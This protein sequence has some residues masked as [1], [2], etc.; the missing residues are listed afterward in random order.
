MKIK[1]HEIPV[2]E[3]TEE[4]IAK[5]LQCLYK[6]T[7]NTRLLRRAEVY[8]VELRGFEPSLLSIGI[9]YIV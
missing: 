4:Y 6:G 9:T 1:L 3:V 2:H 7:K 5:P 8:L